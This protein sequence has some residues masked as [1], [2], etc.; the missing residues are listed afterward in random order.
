MS[1]PKSV[2]QIVSEASNFDHAANI[3]LN[4]ALRTA[5]NMTSQVR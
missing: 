5:Q 4:M 2:E 1:A 3:P